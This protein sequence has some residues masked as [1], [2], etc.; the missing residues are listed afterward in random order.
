MSV[1]IQLTT[2]QKS[3]MMKGKPIQL[4]HQQLMGEKA[5][6][7]HTMSI[8]LTKKGMTRMNRAMKTGKGFRINPKEHLGGDIFSDIGKSV[9]KG[10]T[11]VGDALKNTGKSVSSGL[12]EFANIVDENDIGG[13]IESVKSVVPKSTFKNIL[14]VGLVA[15]GVDESQADLI[16]GGTSGAIYE[17]DFDKPL[18]A[19]KLA[20]GALK[21]ASGKGISVKAK[22]GVKLGLGTGIRPQPK[23]L[24]FRGSGILDS[25]GSALGVSKKKGSGFKGSGL[26]EDVGSSLG[27]S[28]KKGSGFKGSG[29]RPAKG[30]PEMKEKMA[31]LRAMR[32]GGSFKDS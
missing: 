24:S 4:S 16:A 22:G 1:N 28:K 17:N 25:A 10:A 15:S 7:V 31:K 18:Q 9:K 26:I 3:N 11:Q 32:K 8:P 29:I 21:G 19:D 2:R 27:V 20:I 14:K 23:P 13:K 5:D 30:S 6:A 12:T